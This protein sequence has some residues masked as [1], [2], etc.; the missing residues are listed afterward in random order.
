[1][2]IMEDNV[3]ANPRGPVIPR[4]PCSHRQLRLASF[5]N[6]V[7]HV[8]HVRQEQFFMP[9]VLESVP[10]CIIP[11]TNVDEQRI[12]TRIVHPDQRKAVAGAGIRFYVLRSHLLLNN[13]QIAV[14]PRI[15]FIN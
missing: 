10:V 14:N 12:H 15:L 4:D 13:R 7:L 6:D 3:G 8:G 1:M 9:P 11:L 5:R 2:K